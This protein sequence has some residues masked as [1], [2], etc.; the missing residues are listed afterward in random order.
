MIT[1]EDVMRPDLSIAR[2]PLICLNI[3]EE[4]LQIGSGGVC[5]FARGADGVLAQHGC[6]VHRLLSGELW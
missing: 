4:I 3:F 1:R 5:P 6:V 2:T